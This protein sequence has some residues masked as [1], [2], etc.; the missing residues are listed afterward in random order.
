[1]SNIFLRDPVAHNIR[2]KKE[3]KKADIQSPSPGIW[4]MKKNTTQG[5]NGDQNIYYNKKTNTNNNMKG[6][7]S[8]R[9]EDFFLYGTVL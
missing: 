9:I 1:M 4:G 8:Y 2:K 5:Y 3:I 6:V 7:M